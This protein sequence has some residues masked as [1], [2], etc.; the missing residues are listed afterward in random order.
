MVRFPAWKSVRNRVPR[1]AVVR[2]RQGIGRG[3]INGCGRD[4][5]RFRSG[6]RSLVGGTTATGSQSKDGGDCQDF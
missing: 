1:H 3:R 6:G 4:R 5:S 2:H